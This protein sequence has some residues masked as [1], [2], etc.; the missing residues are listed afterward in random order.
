MLSM[1]LALNALLYVCALTLAVG[2]MSPLG[3]QAPRRARVARATLAYAG[4][5]TISAA[6]A[7]AFVGMWFESAGAGTVAIVIVAVCMCVGLAREPRTTED[8]EEDDDDGGSLRRPTP[9]EPTKP[10]GGPSD[11]GWAEFDRA[12]AD[13]AREHEPTPV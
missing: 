3:A 11:D 9:P 8:E 5:L 13:W 7:L 2:V 4:G 6:I 1:L 10:E 12:R